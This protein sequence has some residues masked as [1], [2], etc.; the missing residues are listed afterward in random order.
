MKNNT[1]VLFIVLLSVA[2]VYVGLPEVY[3]VTLLET[4]FDDAIASGTQLTNVTWTSY[5]LINPSSTINSYETH[6]LK[7]NVAQWVG[8]VA[9]DYNLNT[10]RPVARG[11]VSSFNA[12]GN[13]QLSELAIGHT[14]T[15]NVGGFQI[16]PSDMTV[17]LR[18][19]T[20][21]TDVFTDTTNYD[22][23][24]NYDNQVWKTSVYDL[25]EVSLEAGK[26]YTLTL[27]MQNMPGGGAYAAWNYIALKAGTI[28]VTGD[29]S[30][31][32][33]GP[34]WDTFDIAMVSEP[35]AVVIIT[36]TDPN[37]Q[38]TLAPTVVTFDQYDWESIKAVT[39][40]AVADGVL[41]ELTHSAEVFFEV[42]SDSDFYDGVELPPLTVQVLEGHYCGPWGYLSADFNMD[43]NVDF[44][45][46]VK[47]ASQWL[48]CTTIDVLGCI[49]AT[50]P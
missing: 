20:D 18:N 28:T 17:T 5:A 34:T 40:T 10:D 38:V 50:L 16:S 33:E 13:V 4:N 32:E 23:Q 46:F 7:N 39:V 48:D 8:N 2:F 47:L 26:D 27:T 43:C 41:E 49:D 6:E 44:L 19:V 3:A 11:I 12:I 30:V 15:T 37:N 24:Y 42:S 21:S 25:S 22:Y 45:D 36:M 9:V 31:E 29:P 1:R 35:N 14:H